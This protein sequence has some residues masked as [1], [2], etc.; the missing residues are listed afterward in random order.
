MKHTKKHANGT[1][2]EITDF[3]EVKNQ[4]V[5]TIS[6]FDPD[7][8]T[9]CVKFSDLTTDWFGEHQFVVQ[10]PWAIH[11]PTAYGIPQPQMPQFSNQPQIR[12]GYVGIDFG[13]TYEAITKDWGKAKSCRHKWKEIQ[14]PISKVYN[15]EI[16][17]A[18]KEEVEREEKD[19]F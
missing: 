12:T 5:G 9:Y 11:V 1:K 7:D 17:D 2:V 18:K 14:L 19:M 6:S 10:N 15:C 13:S 8:N 16:C 4:H 3:Y